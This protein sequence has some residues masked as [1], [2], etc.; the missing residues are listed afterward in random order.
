[1]RA[2][3]FQL[4]NIMRY[5]RT[6]IYAHTYVHQI[7]TR[8]A[9]SVISE[10]GTYQSQFS[11]FLGFALNNRFLFFYSQRHSLIESFSKRMR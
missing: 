7:R 4:F 10:V 11:L 8:H 1:M 6:A 5:Q 2:K 3:L 9:V